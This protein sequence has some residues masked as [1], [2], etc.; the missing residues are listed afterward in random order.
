VAFNLALLVRESARRVPDRPA[1]LDDGKVITYAELAGA[2]E[3]FAERLREAEVQP[4]EKV[5]LMAPNG[6]PFA[7]A[8]FGILAA[9]AVVVPMNVLLK[10]REVA[11]Y[12]DDS[13]AT[14]VVVSPNLR[15]AAEA[16]IDAASNRPTTLLLKRHDGLGPATRDIELAERRSDDG[17]VIL[18][19]SGTTGRPKGAELTHFNL[20][21]NVQEFADRLAGLRPG[22]VALGVLPLFHTFGQT[23]VL[24]AFLYAGATITMLPRFDAGEALVAIARDKVTHLAGVPTMYQQLLD[25]ATLADTNVSTVRVAYVGGAPVPV[26]VLRAFEARF[27]ATM[28]ELYGLSECSPLLTGNR[29]PDERR[30]GSVGQAVWGVD[31][32]VV[33]EADCDVPAGDRGELVARGP[34]IM[35]GYYGNAD[36]TRASMRGGWF[37]TGDVARMDEDGYVYVVDRL[38]DMILRGGYNV[39]P[40][41]VEEVLYEHPGVAM[42]AVVGIPDRVMG[43]DVRAVIVLRAGHA[44]SAGEILDFAAERLAAY[45]RPR[46]IVFVERLPTTA[47]GKILRREVAQMQRAVAEST[48]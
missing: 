41:E 47:S 39:Y 37:H 33:D 38:K 48:A 1:I 12:L 8:Y 30:I 28:L 31:L 27:P 22:D 46:S 16:G 3:R 26:E 7:A 36:A 29:S 4:G 9:G 42:C 24:N 23:C 17:A 43:E 34:N 20:F 40:R 10:P 25:S 14:A 44:A 11:H 5:A 15:A 19:T 35:R 13:E 45:K 21:T 2:V 18:Y 32:R 6:A